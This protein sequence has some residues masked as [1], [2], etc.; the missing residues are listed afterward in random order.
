MLALSEGSRAMAEGLFYIMASYSSWLS[1]M[2]ITSSDMNYKMP[3]CNTALG[4]KLLAQVACIRVFAP[5]TVT[6]IFLVAEGSVGKL[7]V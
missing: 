7:S 1:K 2:T 6:V 3:L 5:K 4:K